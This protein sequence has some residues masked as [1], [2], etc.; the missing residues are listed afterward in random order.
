MQKRPALE[1]LLADWHD[2]AWPTATLALF[3]MEG[4][5]GDAGG[6][7]GQGGDG[8][9]GDGGQ[10]D[11]GDDV[12]KLQAELDKWKTQSRKHEERAKANA[13]AQAELDKVKQSQMSEQEKAVAQARAEAKAEGKAEAVAELGP[14]LIAAEIRGAAAGRL[15]DDQLTTLMEGINVAAF[16]TDDGEVDTAKV[17]KFV[18]GIAPAQEDDAGQRRPNLDLGQGARGG[19]GG[20]NKALNGDP[21]LRDLKAKVGVR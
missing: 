2:H 5:G 4:E 3:R 17:T 13:A 1:Q 6:D 19:G 7:G 14:R 18:N 21:L 20:G 9:A 11:T 15:E 16:L 8:A 12:A 10:G